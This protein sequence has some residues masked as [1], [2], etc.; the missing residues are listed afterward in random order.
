[1]SPD[2]TAEELGG[3]YRGRPARWFDLGRVASKYGFAWFLH[4]SGLGEWVPRR[5][6]RSDAARGL[7]AP[8]AFRRTLEEL[9]PTAVKLGQALSTRADVLP[10]EWV[11][12]LRELQDHVPPV[13][14]DQVRQVVED[15]LGQSLEDLFASFDEQPAAAASVAQVHFARL[16]TGEAVAVKVQRPAIRQV[17]EGDLAILTQVARMAEARI[18]WAARNRVSDFVDELAHNLRGELDFRIEE[19]NTELMRAAFADDPYTTAPRVHHPLSSRLVLT[20]E[21]VEGFRCAD[22]ARL[23]EAA[24]DRPRAARRL[25]GVIVRQII[26]EGCFHTDPHGG[27]ILIGPDGT[28]YLLDLGNVAFLP[29]Q[30]RDDLVYLLHSL[31]E[32][33]VEELTTGLTSIGA[34]TEGTDAGALRADLTRYVVHFRTLSTSDMSVGQLLE[35]MLFLIY[36][37]EIAMPPVFAQML[38]ALIL[39]DGECRLLDPDFDFRPVAQEVVRDTLW[40]VARPRAVARSAAR[41]VRGVTRYLSVLP[42]QLSSALRRAE[43]GGLKLRVEYDDLDRPMHRLDIMFNRLAFSI[44]IAAMILAPALWM[45]VDVSQARPFWHP[46]HLLLGTGVALGVWLLYSILRSGRL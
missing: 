5:L 20:T 17:I 11:R 35:E 40:R 36:R 28:I 42:Q 13:G 34:A 46:A 10:P 15:E 14:F 16:H 38:R 4:Q 9:G 30:L 25:A 1:L 44:V 12:E 45:Q 23:D 8:V 29:P 26:Q 39:V 22:T 24:V 21:R 18:S 37:H 31:I 7:V 32:G 33:D 2:R 6:A 19:R 43:A 27:N 3:R 41:T